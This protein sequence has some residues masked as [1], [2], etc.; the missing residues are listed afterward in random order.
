M[1]VVI[2]LLFV[3]TAIWVV[4]AGRQPRTHSIWAPGEEAPISRLLNP[5]RRSGK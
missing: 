1:W 5:R 4:W 3:A 2:A